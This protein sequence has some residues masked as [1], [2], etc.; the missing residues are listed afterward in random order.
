MANRYDVYKCNLCGNIVEVMN[1]NDGELTCCNEAMKLMTENTVEAA[2]EKHIPVIAMTE[3][4]CKIKVGEVAH[5]M[6]E[7]HYIEWVE[8]LVNDK[9]FR[10]Y[11]KP[12]D[13]PEVEFDGKESGDVKVRAYCNLHG[14]WK[15]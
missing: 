7:K 10:K 5:P 6:E 15:A 2:V 3:N 1:G 4:G 14:N 8:V 9:V 13:A 12:G 11:M